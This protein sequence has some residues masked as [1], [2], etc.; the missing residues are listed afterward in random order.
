MELDSIVER[1]AVRL[2]A[3]VNGALDA[4]KLSF[5][6]TAAGTDHGIPVPAYIDKRKMGRHLRIGLFSGLVDVAGLDVFQTGPHAMPQK[7]VNHRL[8]GLILGALSN[9]KGAKWFVLRKVILIGFP[10]SRG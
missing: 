3:S 9:P 8:R 6:V 4:D 5:Q 10:S 1:T 7:H 2:I